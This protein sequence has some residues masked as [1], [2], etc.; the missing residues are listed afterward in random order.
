MKDE[1]LLVEDEASFLGQPVAIIAAENLEAL[2]AAQRAV[3]LEVEELSRSS[4]SMR[5]LQRILT[6]E[7]CGKFSEG[8]WLADLPRRISASRVRW[9]S[10]GRSIFIW[11]RWCASS[12]RA[13]GRR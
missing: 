3:I 4:A 13:R 9:T 7:E 5:R 12:C 1:L 10:A 2:E 11:S 6:W 8:I